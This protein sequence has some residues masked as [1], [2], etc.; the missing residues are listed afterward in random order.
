VKFLVDR[1]A[2]RRLAEWL[3]G[4]HHDALEARARTLVIL[5]PMRDTAFASLRAGGMTR[6][7]R[8]PPGRL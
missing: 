4:Q 6:S 8:G 3:R 1:C 2:G 5:I 7:G